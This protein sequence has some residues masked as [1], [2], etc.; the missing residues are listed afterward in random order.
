[1]ISLIMMAAKKASA[2]KAARQ[3][4]VAAAATARRHNGQGNTVAVLPL[5]LNPEHGHLE[6]SNAE[7]NAWCMQL[8]GRVS[9]QVV[10]D[11]V[12]TL[13]QAAQEHGPNVSKL[14]TAPQF[15]PVLGLPLAFHS[16]HQYALMDQALK[17]KCQVLSKKYA[18][19]KIN[20]RFVRS[21]R[22]FRG[23]Y[24]PTRIDL[25]VAA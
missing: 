13:N 16:D 6:F 11:I 1:M 8:Q 15:V 22:A 4:N 23:R 19:Q 17:I 18:N 25:E 2:D 14:A 10:A 5:L 3:D 21:G 7:L 24:V 12:A 9:K 20:V